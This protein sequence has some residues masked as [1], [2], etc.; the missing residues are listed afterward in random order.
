[1]DNL[2]DQL[3][4]GGVAAGADLLTTRTGS[5]YLPLLSK[6]FLVEGIVNDHSL[7]VTSAKGNHADIL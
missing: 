7:L 3:L 1:M 6:H 2:C 4:Y 5:S